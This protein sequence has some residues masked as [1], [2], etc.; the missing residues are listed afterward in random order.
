MQ[1]LV[2]LCLVVGGCALNAEIATDTSAAQASP[3]YSAHC[4]S[5]PRAERGRFRRL[6][7]RITAKFGAPRHRGIDLIAV[8]SDE[9][10]TVA[11]KLAYS[12]TDNDLEGEDVSLFAC[13]DDAWQP[14][15]TAR[16]DQRG[17][18]EIS[19]AGIQRLPAGMR[20]LYAHVIGDGSGVRFLS[21]VAKVGESVIVTDVDGTITASEKA[22]FNTVLFGDDIGHRLG[23][24]QALEQSGRTIVYLSSRGDQLTDVTRRWLR[25]HGFPPGPLRLART[26][27]TK[28][29]A[30]TIEF[31]TRVLR[32]LG[33]PI[34]AG[35][36]NRQTDIA[37]Y[38]SA[39]VPAERIFV[40]L[41]EF[42]AD[43]QADLFARRAI[44]FR[45]YRLLPSML[46]SDR[47]L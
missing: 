10:Q 8:E 2:V 9:N 7:N 30:R 37:S 25:A 13:V 39:G 47:R 19:L 5:A 32:S 45:D 12:A 22:V 27:I 33:V 34:H 4:G 36:G 42:E 46:R 15:G 23:A 16:T 43:V 14:L 1:R 6:H 26:S 35:I 11:G 44:G 40:K 3:G 24:P 28:P 17:R 41:P 18:F 20:D 38:T 29:G 21:F 31:K